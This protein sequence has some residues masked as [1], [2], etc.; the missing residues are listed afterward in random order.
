M[1]QRIT[2]DPQVTPPPNPEKPIASASHRTTIRSIVTAAGDERRRTSYFSRSPAKYASLAAAYA[3]TGKGDRAAAEL[4]AARQLV[5]DDR[6]SSI[7]RLQA[8][9]EF[10]VPKV[11]TLFEATLL[12]GLR[13]AGMPEE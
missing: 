8:V 11:R 7:A 10:G 3:L 13:R 2:A 9:G 5:G 4:A 1:V 12:A 6:Y